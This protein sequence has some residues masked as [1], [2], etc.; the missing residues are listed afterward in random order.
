MPFD[1]CER[2]PI[3]SHGYMRNLPDNHAFHVL[4]KV[5]YEC[6]VGF[7]M[8]G[9]SELKCHA[10]GC[11]IPNELPECILEDLYGRRIN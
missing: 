1:Y 6:H 2:P 8:K 7:I 11:W 4:S 5:T 3:V 10:T 9:S